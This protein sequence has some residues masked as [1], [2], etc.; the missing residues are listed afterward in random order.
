VTTTA[1]KRGR[2]A[3]PAAP[4]QDKLKISVSISRAMLERIDARAEELELPR[5]VIIQMGMREYLK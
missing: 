1:T 4:T 5:S 3:P 2:S